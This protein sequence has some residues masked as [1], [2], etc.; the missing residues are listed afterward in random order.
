[1]SKI[2]DYLVAR[3]Q[4]RTT[5]VGITLMMSSFGF[6]LT[7]MQQFAVVVLGMALCGAPGNSFTMLD[8]K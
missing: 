8:K 6:Q 7:E 2:K 3:L 5:W 1:M 4:E